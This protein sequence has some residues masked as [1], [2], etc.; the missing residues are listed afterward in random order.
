MVVKTI[1]NVYI[2]IPDNSVLVASI[3]V[4]EGSKIHIPAKQLTLLDSKYAPVSDDKGKALLI[5]YT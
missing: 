2:K 1:E 3:L 4:E 5:Y